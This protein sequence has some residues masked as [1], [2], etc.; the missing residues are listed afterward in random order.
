MMTLSHLSLHFTLWQQQLNQRESKTFWS[1]ILFFSGALHFRQAAGTARVTPNL[2][3]SSTLRYFT[4]RKPLS[5]IYIGD[6]F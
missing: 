1:N 3:E 6:V 4:V 2:I 5:P